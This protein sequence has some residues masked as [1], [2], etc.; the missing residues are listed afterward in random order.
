MLMKP[1]SIK[2]Q[3][4]VVPFSNLVQTGSQAVSERLQLFLF[5]SYN[6]ICLKM[7]IQRDKPKD[8]KVCFLELVAVQLL[9][10]VLFTVQTMSSGS[11]L[12]SGTCV[13]EMTMFWS[14]KMSSARRR[15]SPAALSV[16]I[17][18]SLS[19][20]GKLKTGPLRTL[21]AGTSVAHTTRLE[22]KRFANT[23]QR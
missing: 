15:P 17:P 22:P 4:N 19:S 16:F 12:C 14:I 10:R 13:R 6:R 5:I 2:S 7:K 3:W 23:P 8:K 11:Y 1:V 20:R 18:V 21:G 9:C